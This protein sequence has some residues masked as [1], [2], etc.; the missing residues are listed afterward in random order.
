MCRFK[1]SQPCS[2]TSTFRISFKWWKATHAL[3]TRPV[4]AADWSQRV[5]IGLRFTHRQKENAHCNDEREVKNVHLVGI[6]AIPDVWTQTS[7]QSAFE[8]TIR[9]MPFVSSETR[10]RQKKQPIFKPRFFWFINRFFN[11]GLF[12]QKKPKKP[13]VFRWKKRFPLAAAFF[14]QYSFY[15]WM[16]L[17]S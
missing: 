8:P 17:S 12:G 13:G 16:Q 15:F 6:Q 14:S 5:P 4:V 11:P 7:W 2:L 3:K 10:L 1:T 9:W